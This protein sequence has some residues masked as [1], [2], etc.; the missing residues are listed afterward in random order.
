MEVLTAQSAGVIILP[1]AAPHEH[2]VLLRP[3]IT[4]RFARLIFG[5]R[6]LEYYMQVHQ[7]EPPTNI[8]FQSLTPCNGLAPRGECALLSLSPVSLDHALNQAPSFT[9][10][11]TYFC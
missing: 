3:M 6:A 5:R 10:T 2:R 7:V 8:V 4:E 9:K 11:A 1:V